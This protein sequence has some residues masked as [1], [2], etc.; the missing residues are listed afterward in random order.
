[1]LRRL[2][3]PSRTRRRLVMQDSAKTEKNDETERT[4]LDLKEEENGENDTGIPTRRD[5]DGDR[6]LPA[7]SEPAI[8]DDG[9]HEPKVII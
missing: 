1:M 8:S 5:D 2:V 4:N 3:F 9:D 7:A 6:S